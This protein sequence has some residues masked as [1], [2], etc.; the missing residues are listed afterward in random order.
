MVLAFTLA[1]G[2]ANDWLALALVDGYDARH[3]VGVAGFALFVTAMTTGR[4]V[5][6]VAARP[7]RPG[8]GAAR[9]GGGRVRR[10][11][12]WSSSAATRLSPRSAS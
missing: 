2:S 3:W 5:G 11:A 4:L 8:A 10:P 1:E 7:L 6:P 9:V 12:D